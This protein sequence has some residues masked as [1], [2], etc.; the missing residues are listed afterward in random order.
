MS[1]RLA[2]QALADFGGVEVDEIEELWH[3]LTPPYADL[4][5]WLEGKGPKPE[6]GPRRCSGR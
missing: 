4:F 1:A 3:G 2:K 6:S 5:H